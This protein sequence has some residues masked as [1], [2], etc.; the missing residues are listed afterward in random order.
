MAAP[1]KLE[2][3]QE[4]IIRDNI[5]ILPVSVLAEK[6]MVSVKV[7]YNRRSARGGWLKEK[8]LTGDVPQKIQRPPAIYSNTYNYDHLF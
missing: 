7:I 8:E 1:V 5:K 6:A 4:D 2:K 3:W